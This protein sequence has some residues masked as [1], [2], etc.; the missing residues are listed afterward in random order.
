MLLALVLGF[1]TIA[2]NIGLMSTSAFIIARAALQPSIAELQVA[3]V[4]V[5]FFGLARGLARYLERLTSHRTSLALSARLRQWVFNRVEPLEP[6]GLQQTGRGDLLA[7]LASDV[8]QLQDF[9][10]RSLSPFAVSLITI[11]FTLILMARWS[12]PAAIVMLVFV[13]LA[14]L[15]WPIV[16][17]NLARSNGQKLIAIRSQLQDRIVDGLE[18][19]PELLVWGR[20]AHQAKAVIDSDREWMQAKLGLARVRGLNQAV[21]TFM[22]HA[23]TLSVLAVVIPSVQH[24]QLDGTLLSVLALTVIAAFE[25]LVPLGQA[26]EHLQSDLASASRLLEL[27]DHDLAQGPPVELIG[28]P[29]QFGLH[30]EDVSFQYPGNEKLTLDQISFTFDPGKTILIAGPS[31]AGKSALVELVLG[32][33]PAGSGRITAAGLEIDCFDPPAWRRAWATLPQ[34]ARLVGDTL[35]QNLRLGRPQANEEDLMRALER[36]GAAPLVQALPEGLDTWIGEAG[37]QLSGGERQRAALARALLRQDQ[38]LLLDEPVAHLDP[39]TAARVIEN[40]LDQA[41]G[42][43]A[44]IV[45]HWLAGLESVDEIIV[46]QDG[47]ITERGKHQNLLENHGWYAAQWRLQRSQA[48]L[49]ALP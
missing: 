8:T 17:H 33:W 49:A 40:I 19:L 23:A 30:F 38:P 48:Q 31:G 37:Q 7:R 34:P 12:P 9:F 45:S 43:G 32:L 41:R 24:G 15:F 2:S 29:S 14:G 16:V 13:L 42:P 44:I 46:L 21:Y 35:R 36:A 11:L 10:V 25:A 39:I 26:S 20:H 28:L 3:I 18:A 4:A 1:A 6:A 27:T 22:L 47:K 5:R